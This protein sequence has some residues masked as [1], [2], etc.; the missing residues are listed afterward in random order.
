MAPKGRY[1]GPEQLLPTLHSLACSSNP[2]LVS[3]LFEVAQLFSFKFNLIL[4]K[5]IQILFNKRL[6]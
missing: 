4:K 5:K 2:C 6:E 3:D 1:A